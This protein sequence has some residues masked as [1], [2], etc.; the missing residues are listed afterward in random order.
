M[1]KVV[2]THGVVDVDQWLKGKEERSAAI[3]GMGG[4]DVVDHVALDG[5][6][7][8]ALTFNT[9]DLDAVMATL[10]DP[11]AELVDAMD[12]HGVVPPLMAYVER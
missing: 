2:I 5:G 1:A 9:D 7:A 4:T 11:P 8:I 10:A 12:R 3:G 6:T